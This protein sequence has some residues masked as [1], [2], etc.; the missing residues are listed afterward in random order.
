MIEF[1]TDGLHI[2]V[3]V[4]IAGFIIFGTMALN[5]KFDHW[6]SRFIQKA[7]HIFNRVGRYFYRNRKREKLH[8]KDDYEDRRHE[9]HRTKKIG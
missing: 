6:D 8:K 3:I 7:Q 2:F 9:H 1:L 5:G 4:M